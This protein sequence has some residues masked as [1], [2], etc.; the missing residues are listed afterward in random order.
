MSKKKQESSGGKRTAF[1]ENL[2]SKLDMVS[3]RQAKILEKLREQ[4]EETNQV[5]ETQNELLQSLSMRLQEVQDKLGQLSERNEA[6]LRK[7]RSL[8]GKG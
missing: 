3:K 5:M 7:V 6:L 1:E 8:E 2:E 4:E